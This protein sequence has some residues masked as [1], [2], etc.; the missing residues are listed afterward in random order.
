M[1][2][3]SWIRTSSASGRRSAITTTAI[4]GKSS[5]VPSTWVCA[6][7]SASANSP[8][9]SIEG[10]YFLLPEVSNGQSPARTAAAAGGA[11]D[12]LGLVVPLASPV[13]AAHLRHHAGVCL[14]GLS[15]LLGRAARVPHWNLDPERGPAVAGA[16][17]YRLGVRPPPGLDDPVHA[18]PAPCADRRRHHRPCGQTQSPL[19][20]A[21]AGRKPC[22]PPGSSGY[23]RSRA[24]LARSCPRRHAG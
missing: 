24:V 22:P 18:P 19:A 17:A 5:A 6:C 15:P 16:Q 14:P 10:G 21:G 9:G 1:A 20:H 8:R 23:L 12:E 13:R 11:T 7:R 2:Q 4:P 3:N